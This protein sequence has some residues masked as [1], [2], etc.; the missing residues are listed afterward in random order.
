M[1][2]IYPFRALRYNLAQVA[3]RDVVTQPWDKIT[4][5]L[6]EACYQRSPYNLVRVVR[7]LP[8][9]FDEEGAV[10]V[11]AA[12]DFSAWRAAGILEQEREPSIFAWSQRFSL[13]GQPEIVRQRQGF[14]AL[15]ELCGYGQ[16]VVFRHE[17]PLPNSITD[18][19]NLLRAARG[20]FDPILMLYSDPARTAEELLFGAGTGTLPEIE[21]TDEYGV[22]HRMWKISDPAKINLLRTLMEDKKLIVAEGQPAYQA[23]LT[24]ANERT[25]GELPASC[26]RSSAGLPQP[27]YPEAAAMMS[28]VNMESDGLV[29]LPMHRAVCGLDGFAPARLLEAASSYFDIEGLPA[30]DAAAALGRLRGAAGSA[31]AAVTV[32]GWYLL[33]AKPAAVNAALQSIPPRLRQVDA[34]LLQ[35]LVLEKSLGISPEA[36]QQGIHLRYLR[37]AGEATNQVARGEADVAFLMNPASLDQVREVAFAGDVMPQNSTDFY[38]SLPGGLVVYALD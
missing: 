12:R 31:F 25:G 2:R 21:I 19:L 16:G 29:I 3:A 30:G 9:L 34:V 37:D 26:E 13:P 32:Q 15:G 7:R 14:I 8:E 35:S 24:Y 36:I 38:P 10:Y 17:P 4:P 28:F 20:E 23:A 27:P 33:T 18:R 22:V 1:P 6:Q 11:N 5:A